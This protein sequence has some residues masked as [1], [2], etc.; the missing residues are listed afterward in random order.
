MRT[1]FEFR[2]AGW[3]CDEVFGVL[4]RHRAAVC[5]ADWPMPDFHQP[6]T[7]DFVYIRRHGYGQLY[8]GSYPD[9][10]LGGDAKRIR[11]WL[12]DGLDVFVYF[13]NDALGHA[14]LNALTLKGML[15]RGR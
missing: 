12:E 4:R 1:V 11:G 2:K 7:A 3:L 14:V 6:V 13:N 8:G 15:A 5:F 10:H 9:S